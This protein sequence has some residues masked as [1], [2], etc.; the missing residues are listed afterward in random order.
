MAAIPIEGDAVV[1]GQT[2]Y[3]SLA[4]ETKGSMFN[5]VE[6]GLRSI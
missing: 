5:H 1:W 3:E 4:C 6:R 2:P